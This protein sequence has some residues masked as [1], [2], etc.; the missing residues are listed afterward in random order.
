[1]ASH[2]FQLRELFHLAFLRNLAQRLSGRGYAVKGG[3]CLRFFHLSPRLSEDMDLDVV[4]GVRIQTLEN[5]VDSILKAQSFLGSLAPAGIMAIDPS[6]PKQTST[7]QRWKIGLRL[8]GNVVLA[9]KIEF[10]RRQKQLTCETGC[11]EMEIL[12]S[13]KIPRFAARYYG[14]TAMSVQKIRA[15]ASTSR[16]AVRDLFDLHHLMGR[17]GA[18]I[19]GIARQ[20]SKE[21]IEHAA[22]K[23]AN[24]SKQ[25]FDEQVLPYLSSELI[26]LYQSPSS[27]ANLKGEVE[28]QL[29]G[30]LR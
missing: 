22:Q 23:V 26:T 16:H 24:Y 27:F 17:S 14:I 19:P 25:Q 5:I 15:L 18:N 8:G 29:I 9:T 21:E 20:A 3:I 30:L 12:D 2:G 11:P 1:M 13:H 28:A 7:V 4:S 6:K 10:S